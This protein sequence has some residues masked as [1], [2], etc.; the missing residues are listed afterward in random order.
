MSADNANYIIKTPDGLIYVVP[1]GSASQMEE[2]LE[3]FWYDDP[4]DFRNAFE[5][6]IGNA[7]STTD[8]KEAREVAHSY[9]EDYTEYGL[10]PRTLTP[11]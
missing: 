9:D 4:L 10:H 8:M 11:R 2:L 6:F 3:E 1:N 7:F 5:S